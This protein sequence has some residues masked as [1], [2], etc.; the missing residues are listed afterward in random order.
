MYAIRSYYASPFN[1]SFIV[2]DPELRLPVS[3]P[4][5]STA[6]QTI[7]AVLR[8]DPRVEQGLAAGRAFS[9][10][11][12]TAD[13]DWTV[14]FEPVDDILGKNVAFVIAYTRA[15]FLAKLRRDLLLELLLATL[16]LGGLYWTALR[17]VNSHESLRREKH[18]LQLIT[19]TIVV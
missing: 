9:L 6:A 17:L 11:V 2:E 8:Q 18:H 4:P 10:A 3:P 16:A 15:P 12:A 7:N 1:D 14:A 19:D 5:L 13:G